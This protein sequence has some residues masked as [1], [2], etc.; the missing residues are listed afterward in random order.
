V[1]EIGYGSRKEKNEKY[2]ISLIGAKE[3]KKVG[4]LRE[5]KDI[6]RKLTAEK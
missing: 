5:G 3:D 1:R 4:E 6:G 2:P